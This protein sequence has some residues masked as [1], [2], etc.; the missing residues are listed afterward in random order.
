MTSVLTISFCRSFTTP[1]TIV[2][3]FLPMPAL[4]SFVRTDA[5]G[6][7]IL[8]IGTV[9]SGASFWGLGFGRCVCA[10]AGFFGVVGDLVVDGCARGLPTG[11]SVTGFVVAS[12]LSR[13]TE[14]LISFS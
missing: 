1:G 8:A 10:V 13:S 2:G 11:G 12:C 5:E 6:T 7:L 9:R 14:S 3:N 4:L